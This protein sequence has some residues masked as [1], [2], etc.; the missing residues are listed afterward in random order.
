[1]KNSLYISIF[2]PVF[3]LIAL[4]FSC[5]K[6]NV[7]DTIPNVP[8]SITIQLSLPQYAA[9]NSVGNYVKISGGYR[10]IIVYQRA[11]AEY[12][13]FDRACPYDPTASGAIL[14]IDSSG[15]T[16]VDNHCGSK[17]NLYDGSITHSPATRPMKR[18]QTEYD[19]N[20][21]SVYISN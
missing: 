4:F 21:N 15:I 14:D 18:Y 19:A 5:K 1:L 12:V 8:V 13:A 17:F 10:G 16:T 3:I 9:L 2:L 6:S 11:L 20:G 7:Q